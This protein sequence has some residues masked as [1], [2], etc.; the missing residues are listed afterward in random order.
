ML[1]K[2]FGLLVVSF[3]LLLVP[4]VANANTLEGHVTQSETILVCPDALI[5]EYFGLRRDFI[6][7]PDELRFLARLQEASERGDMVGR[8]TFTIYLPILPIDEVMSN[9]IEPLNFRTI[10]TEATHFW[11]GVTW[12]T[13]NMG[14][15]TVRVDSI[16][17]DL[18][19]DNR[20]VHTD[21]IFNRSYV[22]GDLVWF[23]VFDNTGRWWLSRLEAVIDGVRLLPMETGRL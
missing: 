3:V 10:T 1:K 21:S 9:T 11:N 18:W 16:I 19:V 2:L 23:H 20:V 15:F 12:R 6:N 8:T 5:A 14:V 17:A 22:P 7:C 4:M 13:Q